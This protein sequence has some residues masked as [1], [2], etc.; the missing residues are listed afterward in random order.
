[1]VEGAGKAAEN[2]QYRGREMAVR[3]LQKV[4]SAAAGKTVFLWE[5]LEA[6]DTGAPLYLNGAAGVLAAVQAVGTFGGTVTMQLSVD[7]VTWVASDKV[8]TAAG[9]QEMNTAAVA[10]RPSAG[11]G[12]S[13]VDVY[14]AVSRG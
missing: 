10:V 9:L 3:D 6:A 5:G 13:D 7:G 11:S 12:V 14:I 2:E 1:M 4:V 8:F